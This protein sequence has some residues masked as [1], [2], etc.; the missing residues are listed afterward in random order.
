MLKYVLL[1]LFIGTVSASDHGEG[2]QPH[3]ASVNDNNLGTIL[4]LSSTFLI[5]AL[6]RFLI[7]KFLPGVPY[8]ASLLA[9]G[10]GFGFL[11]KEYESNLTDYLGLLNMDP[12]LLMYT[13]LPVLLF[14]SA[15]LL[16]IHALRKSF[17]QVLVLAIPG[18]LMT[19]A[20][21][22]VVI[23]FVF[24]YEWSW[25]G[26]LMLGAILSATDPVA[27][28]ALLKGS[29]GG[30][31]VHHLSIV[32]EGESLLNDGA[33]IVLFNI[34]QSEAMEP[35]ADWNGQY[36]CFIN[37]SSTATHFNASQY[38]DL[39]LWNSTTQYC[40][41][42]FKDVWDQM[43]GSLQ[44]WAIIMDI[45]VKTLGG[46]LFGAAVGF[47]VV[48]WL[49]KVFN[50]SLTEITIT[51]G[52]P[53]LAYFISE[54]YFKSSGVLSVVAL[55][56]VVNQ[57]K[58]NISPEIEQFLNK[59]WE[60]MGY[61]V[62]TIIFLVV[63]MIITFRALEHIEPVDVVYLIILYIAVNFARAFMLMCFNPILKRLGYGSTWQ[64]SSALCWGGL[65]GAVSLAL[66]L[67]V[68][69]NMGFCKEMQSKVLFL[70]SGI[71]VLTLLVNSTTFNAV[72]QLLGFCQI[73]KAKKAAVDL[74]AHRIQDSMAK[75]LD[76]VKQD[77]F[78]TDSHWGKVEDMCQ[79]DTLYN[80]DKEINEQRS[81][82]V[83]LHDEITACENC[84][85][86]VP[87][88]LTKAEL[89]DY[90]DELR[91]RVLKG[92]KINLW[93]QFDTGLLNKPALKYLDDICDQ[94]MDEKDKFIELDDLEKMWQI[95]PL[96]GLFKSRL[97][98]VQ[99]GNK[100]TEHPIPNNV[101]QYQVYKLV[102][103]Q[104]F[105]FFIMFL[106]FLNVVAVII[107]LG[108]N[109][110]KCEDG[111]GDNI[112]KLVTSEFSRTF[113]YLNY[114]FLF[115]FI[116]EMVLKFIGQRKYYFYSKWNLVDFVI[117]W[118]SVAD[119]SVDAY[120]TCGRFGNS[121]V[122]I[123]FNV[124]RAVR[125]VRLFRCVRLFKFI[126]LALNKVVKKLINQSLSY[127]YDIGGGFLVASEEA[128]RQ[129]DHLVSHKECQR[130]FRNRLNKARTDTI[131]SLGVLRK[132]YPGISVAIKTRQSMRTVLNKA[133]ETA[134]K[135]LEDGAIDEFDAD[136]FCK[137]IEMKMKRLQANF[138]VY[139]P[140]PGPYGLLR[141]VPWLRKLRDDILLAIV[142][143]VQLEVFNEGDVFMEKG[144]V[145]PGIFL[146]ISG[147]AKVTAS[148]AKLHERT[149]NSAI[150]RDQ[151]IEAESHDNYGSSQFL[152][153]GS[154]VGELSILINKP[155]GSFVVCETDVQVYFIPAEEMHGLMLKY[156]IIEER[157]WRHRCIRIAL[158][159][160]SKLPKN[161]TKTLEEMDK[162]CHK[163]VLATLVPD[164]NDGVFDID[165]FISDVLIVYGEATCF[166]SG[167]HVAGPKVV[168]EG[169]TK[170]HL[171]TPCK[172]LIVLKNQCD[173]DVKKYNEEDSV[174]GS[175][176]HL[177]TSE[178][179]IRHS[180]HSCAHVKENS[181]M[182]KLSSQN[183]MNDDDM[184][185]MGNNVSILNKDVNPKTAEQYERR[186]RRSYM[187]DAVK[188]HDH[189]SATRM[190]PVEEVTHRD[191]LAALRSQTSDFQR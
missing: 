124:I 135:L 107:E 68:E 154:C 190:T 108:I 90:Y 12:H 34:F 53:Y 85:H 186:R 144:K 137:Q 187:E 169:S 55:G 30:K 67:M 40:D 62:N 149:S 13:F 81:H 47:V 5:G 80:T 142:K 172:L 44:P 111:T 41:D 175:N 19:S 79:I 109:N 147:L 158:T 76:S 119:I 151:R 115:A 25:N 84:D 152:S 131:K 157:L 161:S 74:A 118:L 15:F 189:R 21:T 95:G 83:K 166:P 36:S 123:N 71:V 60:Q 17:A 37:E 146:I 97:E 159:H 117:I 42:S 138:D 98:L 143:S 72:L 155:R 8:T 160:L 88:P 156:P 10:L 24:D 54:M 116:T 39:G 100:Q 178:K 96:L 50:D 170:L 132:E 134:W 148:D 181:L 128:I 16:D 52:S 171:L 112:G 45:L 121:S 6:A 177:T 35:C 32:V 105:D 14:E 140:P 136:L 86:S 23:K 185:A 191:S 43:C 182:K 125:M 104:F 167:H 75:E 11:F 28:V 29:P 48:L 141:Q 106:I 64:S 63:G 130:E 145:A 61:L 173:I 51:V 20:L 18:Y 180:E 82:I 165:D 163:S 120:M 153:V 22:A 139:L 110:D 73:S 168:T 70:V 103:N 57:N 26:S 114:A 58:M 46:P 77:H 183:S 164:N 129:L 66:A 49:A 179:N 91:L 102:S 65:R 7:N 174:A 9:L 31:D 38:C 127:G 78:M 69:H 3:L 33:A 27:V 89:S 56:I 93:K 113:Q 99:R 1:L 184:S 162:I 126:I 150:P 94:T 133:R 4:F 101:H 87:V 59:F 188:V 176:A 122:G 92:M 2:D